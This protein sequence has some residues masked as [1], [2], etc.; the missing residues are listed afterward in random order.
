MDILKYYGYIVS[1]FIYTFNFPLYICIEKVLFNSDFQFTGSQESILH[2]DMEDAIMN[3][4]ESRDTDSPIH[5]P[6]NQ[7]QIIRFPD[8]ITDHHIHHNRH[9]STDEAFPQA[10]AAH[11]TQTLD[12]S[13][14]KP[15]L[16]S[17][18]SSRD[19]RINAS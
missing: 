17:L 18:V 5:D 6:H 4:S 7:T 3:S 15:S 1:V 9:H 8:Q 19:M 12:D 13:I 14:R 11:P 16:I 10:S 2:L